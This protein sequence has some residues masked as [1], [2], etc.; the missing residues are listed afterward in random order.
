MQSADRLHALDAVRASA[1]LLGVALH[2]AQPFVGGMYWLTRETPDNTIAGL[3]YT[4]HMFRMP[5][6]FLIAG[7][8][9]RVMLERR[10]AAGFIKDRSRRILL[11][12]VAGVPIL[13]L[14]TGLAA[15]LGGLAAG[16]DVRGIR[17]PPSPPHHGV[18]DGINLMHLWFLYY[19]MLF[20]MAALLLRLASTSLFDRNGRLAALVDAAVRAL[21]RSGCAPCILAA[22]AA[23]YYFRLPDWSPWGGLP[24]PFSIIPDVGALIAYGS[25]FGLG[26]LLQ[27]QQ[28][29]LLALLEK[30]WPVYAALAVAMWTVCRLLAGSTPHWGPFLK[31]LPLFTYTTCYIVGGWCWSFGLIGLAVR[32]LSGYSPVRR[33]LADA[34]YWIYLLH[35]AALIFFS[36]LL[37]PFH[38]ASIVKYPLTM[39]GAMAILILSYHF[40]VR[41]TFIG[42][43]LNGRRQARMIAPAARQTPRDQTNHVISLRH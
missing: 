1:L 37:H 24:A 4:I 43:A 3:W 34:S 17:P 32:F 42:A 7:F 33:Y 26:W 14:L 13:M 8:F 40:L 2:A 41:F 38:W 5:L 15:V 27:R 23:A 11:P 30:R 20:Y 10:G 36:Q 35:I 29:P 39:A 22:P 18:L 31:D 25:F 6:F 16:M 12:L 19:L 21:V 9:G 28:Q